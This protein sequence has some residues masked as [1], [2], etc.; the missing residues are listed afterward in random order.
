MNSLNSFFMPQLKVLT[1]ITIL[2]WLF[3]SYHGKDIV[4]P[5]FTFPALSP[6]VA[7]ITLVV[8]GFT[9]V[10]WL[11]DMLGSVSDRCVHHKKTGKWSYGG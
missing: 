9:Y 1:H 7:V 2:T 5:S 11:E 8:F 6:F 3:A 4:V 10:T